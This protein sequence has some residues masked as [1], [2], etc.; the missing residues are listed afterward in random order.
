MREGACPHCIDY[1]GITPIDI[2]ISNIT[3]PGTSSEVTANYIKALIHIYQYLTPRQIIYYRDIY[4]GSSP[5]V[6]Q[7]F[8]MCLVRST[9]LTVQCRR[10]FLHSVD[11]DCS[12]EKVLEEFLNHGKMSFPVYRFLNFADSQ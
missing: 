8:K 6:D 2:M 12:K 10:V 5:L 9:Y 7:L 11:Q 3:C 1:Y 4:A